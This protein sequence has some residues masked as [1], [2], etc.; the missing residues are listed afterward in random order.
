MNKMHTTLFSIKTFNYAISNR[1]L[2][3]GMTYIRQMKTW[4][5]YIM[6]HSVCILG[7]EV[8]SLIQNIL[9]IDCSL[10]YSRIS[11]LPGKTYKLL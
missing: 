5:T 9:A 4:T 11:I 3:E 8:V 1:L 10:T 6:I 2:C 7:V